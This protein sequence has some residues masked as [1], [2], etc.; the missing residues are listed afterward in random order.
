MAKARKP[1]QNEQPIEDL[2]RSRDG[3]D[4]LAEVLL[5]DALGAAISRSMK[6]QKVSVYKMSRELKLSETEVRMLMR[7]RLTTLSPYAQAFRVL[8]V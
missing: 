4:A 2:L 7:G 3:Q 1:R 8:Q 5:T 6:D